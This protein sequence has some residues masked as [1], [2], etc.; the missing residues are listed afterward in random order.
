MLIPRVY[1]YI[2]IKK[3]TEDLRYN[4][5]QKAIVIIGRQSQDIYT[6]STYH[7]PPVIQGRDKF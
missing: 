3:A 2:V 1:S 5:I 7:I 4:Q 6:W